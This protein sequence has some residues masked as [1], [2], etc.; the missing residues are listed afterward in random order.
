MSTVSEES[1]S[2]RGGLIFSKLT[3]MLLLLCM[4]LSLNCTI[5][6]DSYNNQ[7]QR[8]FIMGMLFLNVVVEISIFLIIFLAMA[9]T[10]IFRVGL[11]G[12]LLKQFQTTFIIHFI[13]LTFTIITGAYRFNEL[14]RNG[15]DVVGLW[16]DP[17][18]MSLS[19]LQKCCKLCITIYN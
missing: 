17:L 18:F 13:Y 8:N 3:I 15:N 1:I 4:D 5:D 11:L 7:S 16:H 9:S 12:V 2:N 10:Y 6:Y 14:I 19:L